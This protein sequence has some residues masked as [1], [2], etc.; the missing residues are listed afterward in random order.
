L[1]AVVLQESDNALLC[2]PRCAMLFF[3]LHPLLVRKA[4][5][6]PGDS[7]HDLV[8]V[9]PGYRFGDERG[10]RRRGLWSLGRSYVC[11]GSADFRAGLAVLPQVPQG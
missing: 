6:L 3:T 9:G 10:A 1:H 2:S 5:V 8:G 7:F 4:S 11:W